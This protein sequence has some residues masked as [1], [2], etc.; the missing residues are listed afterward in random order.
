[1]FVIFYQKKISGKA[2]NKKVGK[3]DFLNMG[4]WKVVLG[5]SQGQCFSTFFASRHP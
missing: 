2:A 3:I 4:S 1:V 5:K